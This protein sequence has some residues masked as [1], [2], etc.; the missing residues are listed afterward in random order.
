MGMRTLALVFV[1][2]AA[3]IGFSQSLKHRHYR[4]ARKFPAMRARIANE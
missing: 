1:V 3:R 2:R 4:I